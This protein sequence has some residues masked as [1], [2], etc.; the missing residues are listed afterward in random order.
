MN[1]PV[2]ASFKVLLIGDSCQD[3]YHYGTVERISPEAPVPIFNLVSQELRS[4]MADNVYNNLINLGCSVEF[5]AG[6]NPS[7]KTRLI[8]IK[9]K[10]H[11]I[12][13]DEDHD[14]SSLTSN[15]IGCN[16]LSQVDAIVISDYNKG[17][18][19]YDLISWLRDNFNGP[20]FIDT[21]KSDLDKLDRCIVKINAKEFKELVTVPKDLKNLIVTQGEHG[22]TWNGH[23]FP[24]D[25]IEVADVTGA[26]DTFLA[27]L[28][29]K[30][31]LTGNLPMSIQ[32][33][34]KASTITVKHFGVYAPTLEEINE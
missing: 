29:Y 12:R 1:T 14:S 21:K 13:I 28:C 8:D 22:A 10:Q 16:T 9:S 25:S 5:V 6:S 15:D 17:S 4:G 26:G 3:V 33:A 20:I 27:S 18:V 23:Y 24:A 19:S 31:L 11:L 7:K 2:P 32:F 30:Y 34:I